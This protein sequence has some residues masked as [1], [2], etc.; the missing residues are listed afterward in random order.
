MFGEFDNIDEF[1]EVADKEALFNFG[2]KYLGDAMRVV[3]TRLLLQ[4]DQEMLYSALT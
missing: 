4:S 1:L 2:E 3:A